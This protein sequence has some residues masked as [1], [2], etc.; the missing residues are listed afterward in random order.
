MNA[1]KCV[2]PLIV[3]AVLITAAGCAGDQQQVQKLE[4]KLTALETEKQKL[5]D[6]LASAKTALEKEQAASATA[7][8]EFATAQAATTELNRK[9]EVAESAAAAGGTQVAEAR[10]KLSEAQNQMTAMKAD[11]ETALSAVTV[12]RDRALAYAKTDEAK[13]EVAVAALQKQIDELTKQLA[14]AKKELEEA[15]KKEPPE[16]PPVENPVP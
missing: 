12:A 5:S 3:S 9:L 11:H 16:E 10:D 2:A 4:S 13:H 15:K 6:E 8:Q 1:L 14:A 7:K